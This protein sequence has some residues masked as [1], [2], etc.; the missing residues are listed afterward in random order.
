[1]A[2]PRKGQFKKGE[3]G[4]PPGVKNKL[5]TTVRETVL[6]VFNDLQKDPLHDLT[7]FAK[8]NPKEFYQIASKLIPT[9]IVGE[10]TQVIRVL[11]QEEENGDDN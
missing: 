3:G 6:K 5:T 7:K 4:R 9:E 11:Q 8:D 2:E 10:T 1:M